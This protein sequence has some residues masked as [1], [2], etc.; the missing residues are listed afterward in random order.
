M[1]SLELTRVRVTG[2]AG[3]G[4]T[5]WAADMEVSVPPAVAAALLASDR[6]HVTDRANVADRTATVDQLRRRA[7]FTPSPPGS[8]RLPFSYQAVPLWART[9]IGHAIGRMY[10]LRTPSWGAYPQWP[11]DLS[12]DF[13][14]DLLDLPASP[15]AGE[16]APVLLSHD[17]DTPEGLRNLVSLFLPIEEKVGAVSSNY[18]VPCAWTIDHALLAEVRDRGH[19]I[20]IHGYDHSNR[21]PFATP[22]EMLR[23][24]SAARPLIERYGIIGY[25]APSLLRTVALVEA[26]G[27]MYRY[28]SSIPT[29]GG[30]FPV[31]NNGCATARPFRLGRTVEIP[32]T[33]PRDGSL[34]FLGHDPREIAAVWRACAERI[35]ASGGIVSLLTHCEHRF[36]GN[37]PMLDAYQRFL[38][39]L[40]DDVRFTFS[41]PAL[42]LGRL[43]AS[44]A[45]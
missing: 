32:L 4:P 9:L 16:P 18:I 8:S 45:S 24:L 33:L 10:R 2:A 6:K 30:L 39:F 15:F 44:E 23:R 7:A 34:L 17:I 11:L 26:I 42:V 27:G 37:R 41:T 22:D 38:D 28:D 12:A 29:S 25:R 5:G 20:G 36:S 31:P 14:A 40:A 3:D 19:E 35:A 13:L 1:S 43:L 21:T